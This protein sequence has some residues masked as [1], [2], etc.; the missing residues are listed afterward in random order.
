MPGS[1]SGP[2]RDGEAV[3]RCLPAAARARQRKQT[4]L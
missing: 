2:M 3:E 1:G 4:V